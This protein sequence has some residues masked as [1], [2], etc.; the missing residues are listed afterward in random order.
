[1]FIFDVAQNSS[2]LYIDS[3]LSR[4]VIFPFTHLYK[5]YKKNLCHSFRVK[6]T[7][8][9][10]FSFEPCRENYFYQSEVCATKSENYGY[11]VTPIAKKSIRQLFPRNKRN[12]LS[13]FSQ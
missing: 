12:I 10:C 6:I 2:L 7:T 13:P 11:Y 9:F 1:M 5:I 4:N 3:I 8:L